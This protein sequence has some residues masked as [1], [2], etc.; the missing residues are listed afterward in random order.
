MRRKKKKAASDGRIQCKNGI[1]LKGDISFRLNGRPTS[2][3]ALIQLAVTAVSA[4]SVL[5]M[6]ESFLN[7]ESGRYYI[8]NTTAV[9]MAIFITASA[10]VISTMQQRFFKV[11]GVAVLAVNAGYITYNISSAVRGFMMTAYLY[12]KRASFSTPLFAHEIT[13]VTQADLEMFFLAAAFLVTLTISTSCIYFINFPLLFIETFPMFELGTFWGWEPYIWTTVGMVGCWVIVLSLSLINHTTRRKNSGSTFAVYLRKK[14]YYLTNDDLKRRFFTSASTFTV[15]V[16]ALVFTV[17]AVFASVTDNYRPD[18]F[19]ELR[20]NLSLGFRDFTNNVSEKIENGGLE[21]PGRS[22][23]V[24]GTNGGKLGL[25][26]EIQFKGTTALGVTVD[27]PFTKPMY[28]RGYCGEKYRDNCWD[29]LKA[30]K[31][32]LAKFKVNSNTILDYG[33]LQY[34]GSPKVDS[35]KFSDSNSLKITCVNAN[36][37]L[38]YA[39]YSTYYTGTT[40]AKEQDFDGMISP[41]KNKKRYETIYAQPSFDS[42]DECISQLIDYAV[43]GYYNDANTFYDSFVYDKS[44]E[45]YL[46]VPESLRPTLDAIINEIGIDP[47]NDSVLTKHEK[48]CE[49]FRYNFTYDTAPGV[50]PE[51]EDFIKYFLT[52]QKKGY[53]TYFASAGVMLMRELGVPARYVEGYVIEPEQFNPDNLRIGVTDRCAHAWCEI[54]IP[55]YGWYPME[56]T[57]SYVDNYNPN[58]TDRERNIVKDESSSKPEKKNDSSSKPAVNK[59]K[60]SSSSMADIS[61]SPSSVKDMNQKPKSSGTGGNGNGHGPGTEEGSPFTISRTQ[62]VYIGAMGFVILA[63]LVCIVVRRKSKLEKLERA[64]NSRNSTTSVISCYTA[65]LEYIALLGIDMGDNLTDVQLSKRLS[66]DLEKWSPGLSSKFMEVSEPAIIAYMSSAPATE[67]EAARSRTALKN[68]RTEI[69]DML[70]TSKKLNAK[71]LC[72]LY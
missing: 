32:V 71:W 25:Y 14:T 47:A 12:S 61:A 62:A 17:T 56:F 27:G 16:M 43:G 49:Y 45:A 7:G 11:L 6:L 42:W 3:F 40:V 24:G 53:C 63:A 68:A 38:I 44:S 70:T 30:D 65:F 34:K 31:D 35:G 39:P 22:K 46:N 66:G 37:D 33:Y 50:T 64:V 19:R 60:D 59:P 28:L 9:S 4:F 15:I 48:I 20:R 13:H 10:A 69:Y 1:S 36:D 67:E 55:G 58:L 29:P 23:A 52:E 2:F 26:N 5:F 57:N 21:I 8:S 54:F 51:N 18:S 41:E 72:G